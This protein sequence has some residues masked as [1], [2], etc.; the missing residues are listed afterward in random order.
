VQA[1]DVV[2]ISGYA[3]TNADINGMNVMLRESGLYRLYFGDFKQPGG[4]FRATSTD[5]KHY[6][7]EA[8]VLDGPGFVNDVKRFSVGGTTYYLMGLHQNG[9]RLWQTVSTNGAAFSPAQTLLT[10][11]DD[12]D[13]YIV[14]LGWVVR[15]PQDAPGRKLLGALYGA[16]PVSALNQNSIYARW[17]QR[18][19]VFV[20]DDGTRYPGTKSIGPDRQF[21]PFSSA[22]PVTGRFEVYAEDGVTL[23]S[24]SEPRTVRGGQTYQL[25]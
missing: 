15:G 9:A 25:R 14:A 2:D 24:A 22:S 17:L 1:Q 13:A 12:A 18:K 21:L 16:G 4:T 19:V 10:H 8:K 6:T 11:L 20:A 5:G 3:Y 7:F 23:A